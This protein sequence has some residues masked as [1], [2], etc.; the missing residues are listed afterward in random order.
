MAALKH[1]VQEAELPSLPQPSPVFQK[2]KKPDQSDQKSF[3]GEFRRRC[4]WFRRLFPG[5]WGRGSERSTTYLLD[6]TLQ[7]LYFS[8]RAKAPHFLISFQAKAKHVTF[9][10]LEARTRAKKLS[11]GN[12]QPSNLRAKAAH[13]NSLHYCHLPDL[14][15]RQKSKELHTKQKRIQI[16]LL[17]RL[18]ESAANDAVGLTANSVQGPMHDCA[19]K[20]LVGHHG[21]LRGRT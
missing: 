17:L 4:V 21:E 8:I 5:F 19:T 20:R 12:I 2:K 15:A 16:L 9:T 10:C 1:L 14:T 7:E 13:E 6:A 18:P 3:E 11:R